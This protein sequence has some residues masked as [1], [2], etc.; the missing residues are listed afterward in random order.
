MLVSGAGVSDDDTITVSVD[1]AATMATAF[2]TGM[3]DIA[4]GGMGGMGGGPA[5]GNRPEDQ[6]GPA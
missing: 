2:T 1:G 5:T 6:G 3:S 4:T